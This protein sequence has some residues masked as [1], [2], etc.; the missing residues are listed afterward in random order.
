FGIHRSVYYAQVKRPV[1]NIAAIDD[2]MSKL[3]SIAG[4]TSQLQGDL[5]DVTN[6]AIVALPQPGW[7][8]SCQWTHYPLPE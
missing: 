8:F 4:V 1:N 7:R 5:F 3:E 6:G 2:I